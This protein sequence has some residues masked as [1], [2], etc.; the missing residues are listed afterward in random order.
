MIL[1]GLVAVL[2]VGLIGIIAV[3][4]S[5]NSSSED[6]TIKSSLV[7]EQ[8]EYDFGTIAM[9]DGNVKYT[10]TVQNTGDE[11]ITISKLHTSCAC[12]VASLTVDEKTVGPF[13]MEGHGGTV[14]KIDVYIPAGEK[15]EVE[16]VYDP[17][18]HGSAGIGKIE[19]SVFLDSSTRARTELTFKAMVTP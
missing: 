2:I 16:V 5:N 7:A 12:T 6:N 9:K 1:K 11:P 13:G 19:R 4:V 3:S 15:G 14:S 17:A 18:A 10:Y 8:P